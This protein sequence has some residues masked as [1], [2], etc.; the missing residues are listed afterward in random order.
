MLWQSIVNA[1][2]NAGLILPS[3]TMGLSISVVS[4]SESKGREKLYEIIKKI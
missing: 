3:N 4:S 2:E 1:R